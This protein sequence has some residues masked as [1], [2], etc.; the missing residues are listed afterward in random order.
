MVINSI[1]NTN[2][3]K[4]VSPMIEEA[5]LS[6]GLAIASKSHRYFQPIIGR[7]CIGFSISTINHRDTNDRCIS[8]LI[9]YLLNALT[10]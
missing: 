3:A 1:E 7:G 6:L 9:Q 10:I 8:K 2:P 5:R 4:L